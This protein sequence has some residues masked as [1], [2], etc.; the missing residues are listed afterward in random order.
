MIRRAVP[1]LA[2]AL[3]VGTA[4]SAAA[5]D[6]LEA[7]PAGM[8]EDESD[9]TSIAAEPGLEPSAG[10]S[11]TTRE[12][13]TARPCPARDP[14]NG[15]CYPSADAAD[16]AWLGRA[17]GKPAAALEEDD[18]E[19]GLEAPDPPSFWR[20]V[21]DRLRSLVVRRSDSKP[22]AV[23]EEEIEALF[24]T[25]F[26][27]PIEAY[28]PAKLHD[29]FLAKRGKVKK[30]HAIDLGAARGTPVVAVADGVVER[31]GRDRRGGKVVYLKDLTGR[32]TFY[33]AHL[34]SH[35]KGLKAG[36]RVV[37]G[38]RLGEVGA[39]GRVIGGP[40]LHFAIYRIEAETGSRLFAVNPYLIFSTIR[41]R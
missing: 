29:T 21:G 24:S 31:L 15:R 25:T 17:A 35:E 22:V 32:Y 27:I 40:H 4:S 28:D 1:A 33:Y 41:P 20:S 5:S 38:Q 13:G 34:R 7:R 3:L 6:A 12:R 36:D 30:H 37:K 16:L 9:Q 10:P 14:E 8:A 23:P 26:P 11:G 19:E 18:E 39:T 2:L